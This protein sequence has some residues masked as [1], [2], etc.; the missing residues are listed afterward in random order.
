MCRNGDVEPNIEKLAIYATIDGKPQHAARQLPNGRWTSK[1]GRLEDIEHDL[2]GLDGNL[3]GVVH[4][5][6]ARTSF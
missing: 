3:Y 1:L 5:F 2:E 4:T 6:M